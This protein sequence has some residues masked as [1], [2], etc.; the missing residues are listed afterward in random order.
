[1]NCF[2]AYFDYLGF[3]EFIE[4]N[5]LSYQKQVVGKNFRDIESALAQGKYKDTFHGVVADLSHSKINCINFSDTVV[6]WTNDDSEKSLTELL[7][8]SHTFNWRAIDFLFPSRGSIVYGELF[9]SAFSQSNNG[10]G[11]YNIN[12]IFGKGLVSAHIKA[13]AQ[14]WAGTVI[15]KSVIEQLV[16]MGL[17]PDHYLSSYAK[18]YKVPYKIENNL[19]EEFVFCIIKGSLNDEALKKYEKSIRNNFADHNKPVTDKA[20]QDKLENTLKFLES[21]H[22]KQSVQ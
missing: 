10:G 7:S 9:S 11:K 4:N 1:M 20:V 6:F 17:K 3:K 21:F 5:D 14:N 19:S 13:E 16:K 22:E 15:D 18:K 2:I 8:V 12:S